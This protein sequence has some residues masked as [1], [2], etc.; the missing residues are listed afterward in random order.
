MS[1]VCNVCQGRLQKKTIAY[2]QMIE[3]RPVIIEN[4][5]TWIC[6]QCGETYY[7]PDVVER[8]QSIIWSKRPPLRTVET[9]VYDLRAAP[10]S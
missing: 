9:P 3:D 4:V 6:E 10:S 5:P 2:S 1:K 7:D 8:I